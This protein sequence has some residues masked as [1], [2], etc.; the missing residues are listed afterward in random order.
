MREFGVR[1]RLSLF[2]L[3]LVSWTVVIV[4]PLQADAAPVKCNGQDVTIVGTSGDDILLG[5]EGDDVI[6]GLGGDDVIKGFGGKDTI[7]GGRGNDVISPGR[8]GAWVI[9]GRGYDKVSYRESDTGIRVGSSRHTSA[10][11]SS[12]FLVNPGGDLGYENQVIVGVES[13][14]ATQYDDRIDTGEFWTRG[15]AIFSLG[16][17]DSVQTNYL[18]RPGLKVRTGSGD[19][20]VYVSGVDQRI[21]SGSGADRVACVATCTV[22]LG[23]GNDQFS[24]LTGIVPITEYPGGQAR[25]NVVY[26]NQGNDRLEAGPRN[27]DLYGGFG[28]DSFSGGEGYDR[29]FGG[30]GI[31]SELGPDACEERISVRVFTY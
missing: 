1:M 8:G 10:T 29:C 16:G 6:H 2:V 13:L 11:S 12:S 25:G 22:R 24:P 5:T 9:G 17:D 14:V 20:T 30:P 4:G 21:Y 23:K 31:D 26:G 3:A 15:R 27:D 18:S 19:D 28:R 7:C